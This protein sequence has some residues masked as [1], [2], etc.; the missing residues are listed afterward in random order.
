MLRT[1]LLG[2]VQGLTE[3]LPVSS[4]GHLV[5]AQQLLHVEEP[6]TLLGAVLHLGTVVSILVVFRRDIWR[7]LRS[8]FRS[9]DPE[10]R[11]WVAKLIIASI[12]I[13]ITG[14]FGASVIRDAF[15]STL[16]VGI[17]LL[18]TAGLLF[19]AHA[20]DQRSGNRREEPRVRDAIWIGVAQA[21]AILPGVSRSGATLSAGLL[22]G[23]R[24]DQAIRFSFLL[25]VPAV[26]GAAAV[27]LFSVEARSAGSAAGVADLAVGGVIAAVVGWLAIHTLLTV[28][29]RRQ[30]AWF[31]GYCG[32]LGLA[33]IIVSLV[34]GV[35]AGSGAA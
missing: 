13:G 17:C 8:I 6:A 19:L 5:L 12:P 22:S 34:T 26:L 28:V 16:V 35:G 27:E 3:F 1:A 29:R 20:A 4:S 18:I 33:A 32:L 11:R 31:G 23:V 15:D 9:D 10:G 21:A 14:W 25:S 24:Q 30:L 2:V 7:L